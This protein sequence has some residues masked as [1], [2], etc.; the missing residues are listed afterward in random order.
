MTRPQIDYAAAYRQ[1]P[2]PV[3][4]LTPDFLIAD[5]NLA[6]LHTT[7][8]TREQVLGRSVFDAFPDN[9]WDPGA[10]G[11]RNL[12]A[13]LRRVLATGQPDPVEF[14]KHDIEIQ[15]SPGQ[16]AKRYWSAVNA[17]VFGPDGRV[18]LIAFRVE[19]I[20][21]HLHRFMSAIA[22]DDEGRE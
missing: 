5:A 22:A 18:A 1:L 7:D 16:F 3:L 20:T 10:T 19:D 8:H 17:P 21:A 13:S 14:Q 9:P 2:I 11:E 4:L 6:F 12:R 15:G